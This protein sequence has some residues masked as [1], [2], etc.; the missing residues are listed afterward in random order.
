MQSLNIDFF[1]T[2][3]HNSKKP[4]QLKFLDSRIFLH[5]A[6][7]THRAMSIVRIV[8]SSLLLLPLLGIVN[9]D[10]SPTCDSNRYG[11][12]PPGDCAE[13]LSSIVPSVQ[14]KDVRYFVEQQ[15]RSTPQ[16]P[17][18]KAFQDPRGA[19]YQDEIVQLPKWVS[20]G[21][22]ARFEWG[23]AVSHADG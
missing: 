9:A 6:F 4:L 12:P 16:S 15:L 8:Q 23:I 3:L 22:W 18:W 17:V 1:S 21:M 7:A 5:F 14:D 2:Y 20:H 10:L 11:Q 19:Q 13:A